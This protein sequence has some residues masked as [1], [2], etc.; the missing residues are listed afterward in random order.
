MRDE[1]VGRFDQVGVL[2]SSK[3]KYIKLRI[4]QKE[5]E[6][7]EELFRELLKACEEESR[8]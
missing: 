2:V 3:G 8:S 5:L 1:F 4:N 6:E 7:H